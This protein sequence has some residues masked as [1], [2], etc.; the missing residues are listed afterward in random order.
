MIGI[1]EMALGVLAGSLQASG[2]EPERGLRLK[3]E[4]NRLTLELDTPKKGDR[5]ISHN[6][7]SV[8]IIDSALEARISDS[9]IDVEDTAEG[10][11]L[12]MRAAD[13]SRG[14]RGSSSNPA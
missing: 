3:D 7:Q 10:K 12:I 4:G 6:D 9:F 13:D 5:V 2:V 8:L 11:E 14:A 1:S